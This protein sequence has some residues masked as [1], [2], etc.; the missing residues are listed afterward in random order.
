MN[1]E[2][3]IALGVALAIW[4]LSGVL[5][6]RRSRFRTY[7]RYLDALVFL[8]L[9]VLLLP[10]SVYALDHLAPLVEQGLGQLPLA[11][12]HASIADHRTVLATAIALGV[13]AVGPA[14][15][16]Y[17]WRRLLA[18]REAVVLSRRAAAASG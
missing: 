14:V 10:P 2:T 6:A 11:R 12:I 15:V 5:M 7:L 4:A 9:L 18:S 3:K 1:L 13:V 17:G 8:P 16:F